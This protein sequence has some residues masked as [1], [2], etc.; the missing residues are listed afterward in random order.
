MTPARASPRPAPKSVTRIGAAVEYFAAE[1][2]HARPQ[3]AAAVRALRL[4]LAERLG[5]LFHDN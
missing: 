3:E 5:D 4:Q 1:T 2:P